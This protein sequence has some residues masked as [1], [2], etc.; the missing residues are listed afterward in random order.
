MV[1]GLQLLLVG[2]GELDADGG[3][4]QAGEHVAVDESA[5]VPEHRLDHHVWTFGNGRAEAFLVRL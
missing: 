5:E 4:K 2:H 1:I 3:A